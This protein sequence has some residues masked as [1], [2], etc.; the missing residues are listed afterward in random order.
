MLASSGMAR[1]FDR[2]KDH[3]LSEQDLKQLRENLSR[4]SP[5]GVRDFYDR[6]HEDCRLIYTRLPTPRKIQTLVQVWKQLGG[7]AETGGC[8]EIGFCLQFENLSWSC[9]RYCRV[10]HWASC[11]R[12][13]S[14]V[15]PKPTLFPD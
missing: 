14:G 3:V 10:E 8:E 6:A 15:A 7:N 13:T 1:R 12:G 5:Q 11:T 2:D 4:L 9:L